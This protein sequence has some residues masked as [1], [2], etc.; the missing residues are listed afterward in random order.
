MMKFTQ[1]RTHGVGKKSIT[2]TGREPFVV[3]DPEFEKQLLD[4]GVFEKMEDGTLRYSGKVTVFD[5][6]GGEHFVNSM[7]YLKGDKVEFPDLSE[8][9][10]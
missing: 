3:D 6:N 10:R 4:C 9:F 8:S 2:Y 5:E 7:G 1:I